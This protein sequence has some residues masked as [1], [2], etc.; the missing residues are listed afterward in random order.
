MNKVQILA[1][2]YPL[3]DLLEQNDVEN[4]VLVQFLVDEGLIDLDDYFF[5]DT[6]ELMEM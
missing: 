1:D 2:F 4:R 5:D 3:Q 6:N